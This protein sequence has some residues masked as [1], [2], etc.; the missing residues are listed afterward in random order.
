MYENLS[1]VPPFVSTFDMVKT[2]IL[3]ALFGLF[4][5]TPFEI[6]PCHGYVKSIS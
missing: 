3:Y 1:S 4:V 2:K 5:E 6:A